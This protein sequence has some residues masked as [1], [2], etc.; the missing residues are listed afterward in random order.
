VNAKNTA[1]K[2][3]L[4]FSAVTTSRRHR[5]RQETGRITSVTTEKAN[6]ENEVAVIAKH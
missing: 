5:Q 6:G 4:Q 3:S 1:F 2:L